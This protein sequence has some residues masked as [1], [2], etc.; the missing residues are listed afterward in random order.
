M[1]QNIRAAYSFICS[2]YVDGD[3]IILVGFSRLVHLFTTAKG[4]AWL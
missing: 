2:N 1:E 3:D 4:C